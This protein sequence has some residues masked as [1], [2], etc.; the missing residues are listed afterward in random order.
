M[1]LEPPKEIDYLN[2]DLDV[3]K[4]S[5]I[6]SALFPDNVITIQLSKKVQYQKRIVYNIFMM[7]GD[8]GG[9]NDFLKLLLASA[10]GFLSESLM[11]A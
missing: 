7:L 11:Q 10:L 4:H 2:F 1:G 8:V 6:S 3:K 5:N 9:L